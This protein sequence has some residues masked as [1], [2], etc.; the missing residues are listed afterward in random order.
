MNSPV[1][2]L[3]QDS[4]VSAGAEA[5]HQS[6]A[7]CW[8]SKESEPSWPPLWRYI[9]EREKSLL[10]LF[11]QS[12]G[13]DEL[14][15]GRNLRSIGMGKMIPWFFPNLIQSPPEGFGMT[16]SSSQ[17]MSKNKHDD[18]CRSCRYFGKSEPAL[19]S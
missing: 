10:N 18:L 12:Q 13:C 19:T 17:V 9:A 4:R 15:H 11:V 14:G 1:K 5:P 3:A 2:K 6:P 8:R 7:L 16:N